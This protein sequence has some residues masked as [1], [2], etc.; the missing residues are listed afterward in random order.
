MIVKVI[1]NSLDVPFA[2]KESYSSS[3]LIIFVFSIFD[4]L[5]GQWSGWSLV[6]TWKFPSV[7]IGQEKIYIYIQ[8]Q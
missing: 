7:Y 6:C 8:F 1:T 3:L 2:F 4:R 5:R